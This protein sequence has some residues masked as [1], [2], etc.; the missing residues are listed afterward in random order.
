MP[1]SSHL[2]AARRRITVRLSGPTDRGDVPPPSAASS[3]PF[4]AA[5][6]LDEIAPESSRALRAVVLLTA[7]AGALGVGAYLWSRS[8][9]ETA[10]A[11][12]PVSVPLR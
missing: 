2:P 10:I 12:T 3:G 6:V 4:S 5:E 11:A 9:A 8:T 7:V 1:R